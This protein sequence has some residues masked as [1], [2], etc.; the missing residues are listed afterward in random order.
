[1]NSAPPRQAHQAYAAERQRPRRPL[2]PAG[3]PARP[4]WGSA[5]LAGKSAAA[6]SRCSHTRGLGARARA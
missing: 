4:P 6:G 1:M 2:D 5:S 3:M